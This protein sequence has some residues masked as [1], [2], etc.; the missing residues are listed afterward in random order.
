[1]AKPKAGGGLTTAFRVSFIKETYGTKE[2]ARRLGVSTSSVYKIAAGRQSGK[3]IVEKAKKIE[4]GRRGYEISKAVKEG[5]AER[6]GKG[7][8]EFL[9]KNGNPDVKDEPRTDGG[10]KG[11]FVAFDIQSAASLLQDTGFVNLENQTMEGNIFVEYDPEIDVFYYYIG[12][13]Q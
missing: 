12:D 10:G 7:K 13:T 3:T 11:P 6:I 8:Y 5:T 1:M 2:A 9:L 4:A